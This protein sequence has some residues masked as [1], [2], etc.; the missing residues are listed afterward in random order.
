MW[1]LSALLHSATPQRYTPN[2]TQ[3]EENSIDS[4]Y[5][6]KKI[7][8]LHIVI[9][10]SPIWQDTTQ[11]GNPA[12]CGTI[13]PYGLH[14]VP[15]GLS[16]YQKNPAVTTTHQ[17]PNTIHHCPNSDTHIGIFLL[18]YIACTVTYPWIKSHF[19][20]IKSQKHAVTPTTTHT[21]TTAY[22]Y[23]SSIIMFLF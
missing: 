4:I 1:K 3:F 21:H 10:N 16:W 6:Q 14:N 20:F 5:L 8:Y 13:E 15:S 11:S 12:R 17:P 19:V 9:L 7:F 18:T 23:K 22:T 2:P